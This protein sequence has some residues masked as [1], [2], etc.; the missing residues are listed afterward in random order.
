MC[1]GEGVE[2]TAKQPDLLA[3]VSQRE[4][5]R[6]FSCRWSILTRCATSNTPDN[7]VRQRAGS[8]SETGLTT[9]SRRVVRVN[10]T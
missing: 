4:T 9:H 10:A 5:A 8:P 2:V 1:Q 6:A 3:A 7:G